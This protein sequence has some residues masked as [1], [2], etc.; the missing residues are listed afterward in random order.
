MARYCQRNVCFLFL[1]SGLT[2]TKLEKCQRIQII[3]Y[4]QL[5]LLH[6]FILTIATCPSCTS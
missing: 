6:F 1:Y 3:T 5:Q 2:M 4:K